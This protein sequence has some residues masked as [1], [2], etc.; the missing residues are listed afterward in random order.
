MPGKAGS[1]NELKAEGLKQKANKLELNQSRLNVL[2]L[3][4]TGL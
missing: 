1:L 4:I 2:D 3:V